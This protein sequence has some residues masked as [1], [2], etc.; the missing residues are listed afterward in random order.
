MCCMLLNKTMEI[1]FKVFRRWEI[2]EQNA[3][4]LPA[5]EN[6]FPALRNIDKSHQNYFW[7]EK[8]AYGLELPVSCFINWQ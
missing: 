5:L 6:A 2:G 8:G 4:K 3:E 7:E 1:G